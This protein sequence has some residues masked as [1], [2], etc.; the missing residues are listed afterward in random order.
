MCST[1]LATPP[2]PLRTPDP[3]TGLGVFRS[4]FQ[5]KAGRISQRRCRRHRAA[6]LASWLGR[7]LY[8]IR[9][10][11]SEKREGGGGEWR[12]DE[13]G[14]DLGDEISHAENEFV[15]GRLARTFDFGKLVGF[16]RVDAVPKVFQRA[17]DPVLHVG[18]VGGARAVF[19][20]DSKNVA[21]GDLVFASR[22]CR[23]PCNC[24]RGCLAGDRVVVSRDE[25]PVDC[26]QD[27]N[28]FGRAD[29][30]RQLAADEVD[31][32]VVVELVHDEV[33]L[34]PREVAGH[35]W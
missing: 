21:H 33:E 27:F 32:T 31:I 14:V 16:R 12:R 19:L 3:D 24:V 30:C 6:D 22:A 5:Q 29:D 17:L 15:L 18:I 10:K 2:L 34:L 28:G 20:G 26:A 4:A 1:L 7:L 23:E 11:P 35:Y 13:H 8:P 9:R 25:F